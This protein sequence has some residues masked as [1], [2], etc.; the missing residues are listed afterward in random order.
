MIIIIIN[1]NNNS[2]NNLLVMKNR[3]SACKRGKRS[4]GT[5][6]NKYHVSLVAEEPVVVVS[7]FGTFQMVEDPHHHCFWMKPKMIERSLNISDSS[8]T[9]RRVIEQDLLVL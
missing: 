3:K 8:A 9:L 1:D 2:N 4:S 6:K 5:N 7:Q